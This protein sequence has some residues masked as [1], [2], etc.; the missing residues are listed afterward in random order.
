MIEKN[1][2]D[3]NK[4][5][6]VDNIE[7]NDYFPENNATISDQID[8]T[9]VDQSNSQNNSEN[10]DAVENNEFS[11]TSLRLVFSQECWIEIKDINGNIVNSSVNPLIPNFLLKV[12]YLYHLFLVM[13]KVWNYIYLD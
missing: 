11:K 7:Q 8:Q 3:S 13:Q 1:K 4:L 9:I 12:V 5:S 6:S 2:I 10:Y